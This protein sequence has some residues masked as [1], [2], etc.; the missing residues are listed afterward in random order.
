M[1]TP[2]SPVTIE[3]LAPLWIAALDAQDMAT[4]DSLIDKAETAGLS[5]QEWDKFVRVQRPEWYTPRGTFRLMIASK[6]AASC[7][8]ENIAQLLNIPEADLI[9]MMDAQNPYADPVQ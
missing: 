1:D 5:I 6:G 9:Q 4:A 3:T 7:G 2:I 8:I